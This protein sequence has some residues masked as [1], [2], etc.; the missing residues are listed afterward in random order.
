MLRSRECSHLL[1]VGGTKLLNFEKCQF[2]MNIDVQVIFISS[3]RHTEK[4]IDRMHK[5]FIS[6]QLHL[7]VGGTGRG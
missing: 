1:A 3:V 5:Q 4:Y 2:C 6:Y 7:R